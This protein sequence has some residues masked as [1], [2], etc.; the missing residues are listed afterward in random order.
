MSPIPYLTSI[1]FDSGALPGL[2]DDLRESSIRNPLIVA[3]TGLERA[4]LIH[5]LR[6]VLPHHR[7]ARIGWR[8]Y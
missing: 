2:G 1:R 6:N 3:D 7:V 5:R 8:T 4:G